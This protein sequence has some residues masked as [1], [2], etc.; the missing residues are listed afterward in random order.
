VGLISKIKYYILYIRALIVNKIGFSPLLYIYNIT[1][2]NLR[3]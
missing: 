1:T 3:V 2:L